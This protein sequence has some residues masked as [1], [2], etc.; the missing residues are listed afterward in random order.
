VA[1]TCPVCDQL[2]GN[3]GEK[4]L[5]GRQCTVG[6]ELWLGPVAGSQ[7]AVDCLAFVSLL[8]FMAS[9][10]RKWL[11]IIVGGVWSRTSSVIARQVGQKGWNK[12][13]TDAM[14]GVGVRMLG[15]VEL[16]VSFLVAWACGRGGISGRICCAWDITRLRVLGRCG[17]S[18]WRRC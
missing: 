4:C 3:G 16:M 17:S 8:S 14:L 5:A 2:D 6:L 7:F 9:R 13:G 15:L 10:E 12:V 18:R 11:A 1:S